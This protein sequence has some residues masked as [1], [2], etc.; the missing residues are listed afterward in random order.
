MDPVWN[1]NSILSDK[2]AVG[3]LLK[4]L[5]GYN[6]NPAQTEILACAAHVAIIG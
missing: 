2:S 6:G 5:L 1:I 3:E 4:G